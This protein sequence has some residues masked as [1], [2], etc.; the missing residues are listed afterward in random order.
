MHL[1]FDLLDVFK[2]TSFHDVWVF[3]WFTLNFLDKTIEDFSS[4]LQKKRLK[5][6]NGISGFKKSGMRAENQLKD[7]ATG[8]QSWLEH[9]R[10]W[11]LLIADA[12]FEMADW[13]IYWYQDLHTG[14]E[15]SR[16][17]ICHI[18]VNVLWL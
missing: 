4:G 18:Q 3:S 1:T 6:W 7:M 10:L 12:W 2:K 15:N 8:C 9:E 5:V 14:F 13:A 11:A 17:L 16:Q